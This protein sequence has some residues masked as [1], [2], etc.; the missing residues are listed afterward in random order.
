MGTT[1]ANLHILGGDEQQLHTLLPKATVGSWSARFVS[2]YFQEFEPRLSEKTARALSK[3]LVQPVLL[4]WIFDSDAVGFVVYQGGKSIAEHILD[5]EGHDKM[6]NI[7]LFCESLELPADDV[8]RLRAVWK[9]GDAEEQMELTALL[10][11]LPLYHSCDMLPD[12]QH[13]RDSEAVD[14]WIAE[15]PATPKIKSETK[16]VL[17]Q[18]LTHFR[19]YYI[20]GGAQYCS[21]E[22][23]DDEYFCEKIQ[24]WVPN[25]DGTLSPGW[26]TEKNLHFEAS[27]D[28][29][30]GIDIAGGMI[31]YDSAGLLPVG[32]KVKDKGTRYLLPDG[33]ILWLCYSSI[34]IG[35]IPTFIRCAPD[36]SDLWQKSGAY[37]NATIFACE[38]GEIIFIDSSRDALWL[39]R[40]DW[41]TGTMVE[42]ISRP[43]GLNT[44]SK[45]Y[46][47]GFWWVAHDGFLRN[48]KW[49]DKVNTLTKLDDKL[50][51][52]VELPLPS[53]TQELFFSPDHAHV[54]VFFF[55]D[56]VMVVDA[57]TFTVKNVLNDKSYLGPRG[58]DSAGRFWLQRDN[59][60]VEAWDAALGATRSRHKL[61]GEIMGHH[62]TEQGVMCVVAWSKKEKVLRVYRLE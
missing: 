40:V 42:R 59:S 11:G 3:K 57:E 53:Y 27:Q 37:P 13:F 24:F 49:T 44:W 60:T 54:Y 14:K 29:V 38:N 8:P 22:P 36:G 48:V 45:A 32:Y 30:L 51:P 20:G 46:D 33:G 56:Q 4:A 23:Y 39:E 41:L 58:F 55:K 7:A 61:K 17:A 35:A 31:G 10:L 2:A 5:P 26:A 25:E 47:N 18:E 12:Q 34:E 50:R 6:G 28:R 21:A 16:A 52:I 62:M 43:F 19:R 15:R 9:K 1:L